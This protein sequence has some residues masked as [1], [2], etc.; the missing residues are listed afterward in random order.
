MESK[1]ILHLHRTSNFYYRNLF[2]KVQIAAT[3]VPFNAFIMVLFHFIF[4]E[5]ID[6]TTGLFL[7]YWMTYRTM[8]LTLI[9]GGAVYTWVS[10]TYKVNSP[11]EVSTFSL[12][13]LRGTKGGSR[14]ASLNSPRGKEDADGLSRSK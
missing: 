8:Q 11:T 7:F 13:A 10:T 4:L 5:K 6:S 3:S 9:V 14:A 12:T 1:N 2:I